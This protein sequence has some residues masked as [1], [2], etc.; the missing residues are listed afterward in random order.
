[1]QA[2][3]MAAGTGTR[4]RPLTMDTPKP[5]LK[6]GDQ[7]IIEK[8]LS[9]LPQAVNEVFV[10]IGHHGD[11]IEK[12]IGA[13]YK[14]LKI[15]YL[16]QKELKGTWHAA[17]LAKDHLRG[18]FLVLNGDDIY[19]KDDLE[20]LAQHPWSVMAQKFNEATD[21]LDSLV[22]DQDGRLCDVVEKNDPGEKIVNTGAYSLKPEF[23]DHAPIAIKDGKEYG[24]PQ[25]LAKVCQLY[26]VQVV[27]TDDW[28]KI[29]TLQDLERARK[30]VAKVVAN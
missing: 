17:S 13:N 3:I 25:T 20:K 16:W 9:N 7:T 11:K 19:K 21:T 18:A 1:M 10:I 29:N 26:P 4:L 5:L 12:F 8:T 6:L 23:F 15:N 2:I 27:F 22:L 14:N 30:I 28:H 24:L